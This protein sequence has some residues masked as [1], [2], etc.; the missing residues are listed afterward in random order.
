MFSSASTG[1]QT[2]M[3]G[4]S[5]AWA[6]ACSFVRAL[7]NSMVDAFGWSTQAKKVLA[8]TEV[9]DKMGLAPQ[10]IAMGQQNIMEPPST[11]NFPPSYLWPPRYRQRRRWVAIRRAS[12]QVDKDK[13]PI[14]VVEDDV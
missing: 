12:Q 1:A 7:S 13:R 2:S 6:L 5:Q 4:A 11:W 3:T 10:I 14:L 9:A 8:P